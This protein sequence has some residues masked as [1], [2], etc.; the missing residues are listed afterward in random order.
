M[1]MM[2]IF[3]NLVARNERMPKQTGLGGSA[4]E[5]MK[6][7]PFVQPE[8]FVQN[9]PAVKKNIAQFDPINPENI[10]AEYMTKLNASIESVNVF[11]ASQQQF[12]G[13]RFGVHEKSGYYFAVLRDEETGKVLKQYP[14]EAFLEIA[15]RL[16]EASG[17]LVDIL[18]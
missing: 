8:F 17:L 2:R 7:V 1:A 18:G 13:V 12:K 11:L 16:K 14:A 4:T 3:T 9:N 15:A 10:R 5:P 6:M